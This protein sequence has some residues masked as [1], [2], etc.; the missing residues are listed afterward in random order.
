MGDYET[1]FW[2]V[3]AESCL[4]TIEEIYKGKATYIE[5]NN[6]MMHKQVL[7]Q[8]DKQGQIFAL[9][10]AAFLIISIF[11]KMNTLKHRNRFNFQH[12]QF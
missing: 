4:N 8:D 7:V 2:S 10:K 1:F 9:G 3:E 11:F 5:P 12:F 6:T